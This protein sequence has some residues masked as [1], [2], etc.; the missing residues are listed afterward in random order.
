M[1]GLVS[2]NDYVSMSRTMASGWKVFSFIFSP[3]CGTRGFC[4][5][6]L[7]ISPVFVAPKC[8]SRFNHNVGIEAS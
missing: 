3:S 5:S 6:G 2:A 7:F 8:Q 1:G 4:P